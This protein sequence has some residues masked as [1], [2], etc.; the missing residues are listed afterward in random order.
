MSTEILAPTPEMT[1]KDR[2][3]LAFQRSDRIQDH[4]VAANTLERDDE[5]EREMAQRR[6]DKL[7]K[8]VLDDQLANLS[9]SELE[10]KAEQIIND[11]DLEAAMIDEHNETPLNLW[12]VET[13]VEQ[14]EDDEKRFV[15][16]PSG[17]KFVDIR[18]ID[19]FSDQSD[20]AQEMATRRQM[21]GKR[22]ST[23][24]PDFTYEGTHGDDEDLADTATP[25]GG[26]QIR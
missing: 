17:K 10:K 1:E 8:R 11:A 12:P 22:G 18:D 13:V 2:R 16:S 9:P 5:Y 24:S 21:R 7:A 23:S 20:L 4:G 14:E 25:M 26:Y 15:A 19:N 6:K 3:R